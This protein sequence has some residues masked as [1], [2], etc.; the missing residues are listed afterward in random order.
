M[1]FANNKQ[2]YPNIYVLVIIVP[3]IHYKVNIPLICILI[4][5]FQPLLLDFRPITLCYVMYYMIVVMWFFIIQEIKET[6][7]EIKSKNIYKNEIK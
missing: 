4:L 7:K 5:F 1:V 3:Y 6:E 2:P